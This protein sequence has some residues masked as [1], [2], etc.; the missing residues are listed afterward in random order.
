MDGTRFDAWTRRRIGFAAGNVLGTLGVLPTF[1]MSAAKKG[2]RKRRCK[3]LGFHP[4][5]TG[6]KK[7]RCCKGLRCEVT[8]MAAV[9]QCCLPAQR[10]CNDMSEFPECCGE[11]ACDTID[12]LDGTRCSGG[13]P[14][15][16]CQV[17]ADCCQFFECDNGACTL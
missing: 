10:L 1:A 4:C 5:K 2:K 7:R 14:G 11:Q 13:S 16:P 8:G 12:G 9:R 3:K 17:D 6:G 15:D